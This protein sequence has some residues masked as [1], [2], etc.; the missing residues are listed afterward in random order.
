[1]NSWRIPYKILVGILEGTSREVPVGIPEVVPSKN[2][3]EFQD[4]I[5]KN[6]V[7]QRRSAK[8][9]FAGIY[10]RILESISE[11]IS[12][13]IPNESPWRIIRIICGVREETARGNSRRIP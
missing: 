5:K 4:S 1:M 10:E 6:A 8:R 9:I 2:L 13:G 11:I 12:G 7:I 3:A